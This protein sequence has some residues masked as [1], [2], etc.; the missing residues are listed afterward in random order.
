MLNLRYSLNLV[1]I[2][3]SFAICGSANAER[4]LRRVDELF[5]SDNSNS[6]NNIALEEDGPYLHDRRRAKKSSKAS[7]TGGASGPPHTNE[8]EDDG[9]DPIYSIQGQFQ[10]LI[11]TMG[12]KN[13]TRALDAI[14]ASPIHDIPNNRTASMLLENFV[15]EEEDGLCFKGT[16]TSVIDR[17]GSNCCVGKDACVWEG[18]A[19]VCVT[20]C[21]GENSC[22]NITTDAIIYP[23]S[24]K[25]NNACENLG[26]GDKAVA[27][28]SVQVGFRAC[29]GP[30]ACKDLGLQPGSTI[31]IGHGA[32]VSRNAACDFLGRSTTGDI[33]IGNYACRDLDESR[34]GENCQSMNAKD[35]IHVGDGSCKGYETCASIGSFGPPKSVSIGIDS[36]IG[37]ETCTSMGNRIDGDQTITI[38]DASCLQDS[39]CRSIGLSVVDGSIAIGSGSCDGVES[40]SSFG[41]GV[42]FFPS[43]VPNYSLVSI[44][45]RACVG[46]QICYEFGYD[47]DGSG[48]IVSIADDACNEIGDVCGTQTPGGDACDAKNCVDGSNFQM[49]A[50]EVPC[51]DLCVAA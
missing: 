34:S 4:D 22:K 8:P 26:G 29:A 21:L 3:G 42:A 45:D 46:T 24:C 40:C 25:G 2:V 28:K 39:A 20:S 50:D 44:G 12:F 23:S 15:V 18:E 41:L 30:E 1:F 47:L 10:F 35:S 38:G 37:D 27:G 5:A 17:C 16:N 6:N 13:T 32:C 33:T 43:P 7:S 11:E 36:C 51:E 14:M 49:P 48:N 19:T 31:R 9:F